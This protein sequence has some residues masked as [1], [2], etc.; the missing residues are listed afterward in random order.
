MEHHADFAVPVAQRLRV[1][2][3]YVRPNGDG[4]VAGF[5][6]ALGWWVDKPGEPASSDAPAG[7][8]YLLVDEALPCPVWCAQARLT[9]VRLS[10]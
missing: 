10:H 4:H 2:T 7:V 3:D 9:S 8:L 5:A 1:E 6:I